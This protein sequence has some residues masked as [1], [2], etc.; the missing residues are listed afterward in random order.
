ME[1]GEIGKKQRLTRENIPSAI[2]GA[3][4]KVLPISV[5]SRLPPFLLTLLKGK[6]EDRGLGRKGSY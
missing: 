3:D 2:Y 6:V 1:E 4:D 5:K